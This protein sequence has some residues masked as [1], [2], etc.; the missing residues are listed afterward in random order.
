MRPEAYKDT[1]TGR[2]LKYHYYAVPAKEPKPTII[3]CHGF[4]STSQD[5]WLIVPHFEQQGYGIIVPDM[6]GFGG[7]DKP[8]DP[9]FYRATLIAKD[10][11]D[12]LNAEKIDKVIGVGHD[13]L[14]FGVL[15]YDYD[16]EGHKY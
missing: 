16:T 14:V 3:F 1:T 4:P 11:V 2:G 7:T 12:I 9:S 8:T 13:W 10:I 6:L 15:R 5:W